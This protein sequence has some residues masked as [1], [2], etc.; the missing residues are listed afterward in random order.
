MQLLMEQKAN[1]ILTAKTEQ[2]SCTAKVA[3]TSRG[4]GT[5]H[6]QQRIREQ[7]PSLNQQEA[8]EYSM[9]DSH[10][11]NLVSKQLEQRSERHR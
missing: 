3:A 11:R 10:Q 5:S 4:N 1:N 9:N 6:S 2:K 7:Q 8:Q